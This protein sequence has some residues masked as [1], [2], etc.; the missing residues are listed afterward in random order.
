MYDTYKRERDTF[1]FIFSISFHLLLTCVFLYVIFLSFFLKYIWSTLWLILILSKKNFPKN[2]V[3]LFFLYKPYHQICNVHFRLLFECTNPQN[4][5]LSSYWYIIYCKKPLNHKEFIHCCFESAH[6][7]Y[8]RIILCI[9]ITSYIFFFL[10]IFIFFVARTHSIAFFI[11]YILVLLFSHKEKTS[12][13]GS[14]VKLS[15]WYRKP[16]RQKSTD[17]AQF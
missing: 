6:T 12:M 17:L 11:F 8:I 10:T 5:P 3:T 4:H 14:F 9:H 15:M 7:F 2:S 16:K 13:I 1:L